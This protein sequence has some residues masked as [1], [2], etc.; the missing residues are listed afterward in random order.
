MK[1]TFTILSI[2]AAMIF[3]SVGVTEAQKSKIRYADKQM[4][5]MNYKHALEVYEQSYANKPGFVAAKKIAGVQ[6]ILRD[7]DKSYEWWK[8][9]V[10]YEEAD[11]SDLAQYLRAAQ[12]TDNFDEAVGIIEAKG[13][14]PD[15]LDVAKLLT[16]QSR[17]KVKLEAVE[18]LNSAGS[19]FDLTMDSD[20]NKYFVSDRGGI[21]PSEMPRLRFDV[22]NQ[23]FSDE[24]HDF[25]AREYFSVYK[26]DTT[27]NITELVSNVPGTYN[28]SDPSYDKEQGI[29]FYSVTRDIK[30]VKKQDNIIV[31]P[32]IYYSKLNADGALDGFYPVPFNDS[33]GYAVMNPFVDEQAKR[34]YFTS[35]MPGGIGGTDLYYATYDGDMTFGAPVNLGSTINTAGNESHAFRQGDKFYFSSTGHPGVGGMDI[36]RSNYTATQFSNSQNLGMP[37]NSVADD[38]AYRELVDKDGKV[39]VYLSSNRNGGQGL[40]DIYIMQDVYKQFLARV[41]DCDGLVIN[42][43]YMATLRDKTQNGN[44]QTTRSGKGELLAELE[45][46]S[47]F[48]IVISKPGYFSVTDES[49]TTKGFE[50]DTVKREYTLIAIPYQLPVHVD[51]VYYDLDKFMIRDDAKPALD[52]LG[53]MMNKYSF[54]DL[55][56]ASHTDS[57]ASDEYNIILSNNRAK[58]VTEYM[59]QHNISADRIRLEW[60]GEQNLV[61]DCGNGKPCPEPEHQ[62]NRRSELILEAFPDPSKQYE[63]P[64]SF[65]DMDFCDPETLFEDIQ[66]EL[67]AIPTIYFDFDKSMLRS[68]HKK[69]LERTAIMLTRMP[70]LMLYIEGH[71]DQR[72]SDEY[73]KPLS[74]RRAAVV[75]KYLNSRGIEDSRM[76]EAWFGETK[77]IHNCSDVTCTEAMHKLNRRTE[78]RVGKSAFTYTGRKKKVD[79][80]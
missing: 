42:D 49:I 40:D 30:K 71:T 26:Q 69:E 59:A 2:T 52:K 34:L 7:Y 24:K 22:K 19:D 8:T 17:R 67:A 14:S 1:K 6:D 35:D 36:F 62:L 29:L 39:E 12:L 78:L 74:E 10:S 79:T 5:L 48:G 53:E 56:V 46:D 73:N 63:I 76:E 38:F 44:V 58:A 61:N 41:I 54:L 25:T 3:G 33:I 72:G 15:S 55:L 77:P 32:E 9:T 23:F 4:E 64:E 66:K 16:L 60:F 27:G 21:Y 11:N 57:R 18:G 51:I 47:D 75:M 80:L 13:V 65:K 70:N 28:F 20:G 37:I 50:G 43:N 31:Q 68:V 45:P